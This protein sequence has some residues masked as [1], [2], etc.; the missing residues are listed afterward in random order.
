M[1]R[2]DDLIKELCPNGV[3]FVTLEKLFHIKGGYTP[4]KSN[5]KNWETSEIPWF[6]ME[7][8]REN[9]PVLDAAL[10]GVSPAAVKNGQLFPADSLIVATS[11]TIGEHALIRVPYLCNQRFVSLQVKEEFRNLV[12]IKFLHYYAYV[13]DEWCLSN[14]TQSSFASVQMKGFKKFKF[15]IPPL[16]IQQEIAKILDKF[17][18]LEAEL[19]AELEARRKQYAYYLEKLGE[20]L[21]T[22]FPTT[23]LGDVGDWAG[24]NTPSKGDP[25]YWENGEI[26]WVSSKDMKSSHITATKFRVTERAISEGPARMI[27]KGAVLVVTRSSILERTLPVANLATEATINQ[28]IKAIIPSGEFDHR[29]IYFAIK[30]SADEILRTIR[31]SGGS[32]TSLDTKKLKGFKIPAPPLEEQRRIVAILDKFDALVNDIS[33][34]LPAE[35]AARRKQYEY[36]RDKLLS[37]QPA[38]S[39]QQ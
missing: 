14:T 3:T 21:R 35:I 34:G 2:V 31:K 32:V 27:P 37:F 29:Y 39:A 16:E 10:S 30:W 15:P 11:A 17:T 1:S 8:I 13:L 24:G 18:Q 28:D 5:P 22:K 7:D 9:G 19:E 38:A 36:Y 23:S 6:R 26:L 25:K 33:T 4:P 12:D 20:V